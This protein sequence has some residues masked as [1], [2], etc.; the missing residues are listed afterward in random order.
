LHPGGLKE[1]MRAPLLAASLGLAACS[2][3]PTGFDDPRAQMS[4]ATAR[5]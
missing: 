5:Q 4:A 1:D 3:P 2:Q